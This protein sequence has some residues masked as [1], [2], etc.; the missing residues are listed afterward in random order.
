ML[1][2]VCAGIARWLHIAPI[3]VRIL[4][5]LFSIASLGTGVII[6]IIMAL[7]MPEDDSDGAIETVEGEV[8]DPV[9]PSGN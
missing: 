8:L 9:T 1:L 6:Y 3:V 5:A 7:I 2:G 4:W